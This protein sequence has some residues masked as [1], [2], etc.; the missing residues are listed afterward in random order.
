MI[1]RIAMISD[2]ASPL[3]LL[4]GVDSGGQNVYVGQVAKNL[5]HMGYQ[6]DVFTRKDNPLLPE[7]VEWENGVQVIHVPAGPPQYVRKEDL[8]PYMDEFTDYMIRYCEGRPYDLIHAHF[9]M[10]GLVAADLKQALGIP[11]LITFHAL[12]K[13]RRMHQR[14]ADE[15]PE[16]R[17]DIEER[18]IREADRII[19]ECPQDYEDLLQLYNADREKI[20]IVPCGFDPTELWPLRK[21]VA[22]TALGFQPQDK[23]ILQLGRM[24]RRK[25][26]DNV[27]HAFSILRKKYNMDAKL[28][29]VGGE[30]EKVNPELTPEIGRLL[31]I[32]REEGI[33]DRLFFMGRASR[34]ELK[35]Y[36]SAADVFL[37]TPWYEP[38][39]ITPLES[40]ACGTPVIGTEVGGLKFTVVDGETGFLVPVNDAEAIAD[41]LHYLY[42][43]PKLIKQMGR[44]AIK[45]ANAHFTWRII[46]QHI[47]SIYNDIRIPFM[48]QRT[49]A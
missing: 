42:S 34:D 37:S 21:E 4:G 26:V 39:G 38:F 33:M 10:S 20:A 9:W 8:P 7:V 23:I 41:R 49:A 2:H 16:M 27:L 36:Y 46:S 43:N 22:R 25:G 35:Y 6:V 40:M 15:F 47:A 19:A 13:V 17:F 18:I 1:K 5:A 3:A 12:G 24:V 30:S 11:F 31:G 48:E 45:R 14:E 32:A 29:I 28:L 44:Q